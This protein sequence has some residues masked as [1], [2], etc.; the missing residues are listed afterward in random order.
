MYASMATTAGSILLIMKKKL[1][2]CRQLLLIA[3]LILLDS[4]VSTKEA[5]KALREAPTTRWVL[6]KE[7]AKN[8]VTRGME[9]E[10]D[11]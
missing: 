8:D 6:S 3:P 7:S 9:D 10:G 2:R 1:K 11:Y 4:S 5:E